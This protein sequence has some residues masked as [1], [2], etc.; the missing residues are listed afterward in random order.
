[1]LSAHNDGNK[2]KTAR[3]IVEVLEYFDEQHKAA[4]VMD[5]V[6]RY[7]RP[8]SSTSEL[9][10]TLVELG[11]LYKDNWSR[12]YTLTP[13]AAILG[14]VAQPEF[15]RHGVL[16]KMIDALSSEYG[17]SMGLF[18]MVGLNAQVFR[19]TLGT[20]HL[21]LRSGELCNGAQHQLCD[22][23]VGLLLLSTIQENR[24]AGLLRRLNAEAPE[25]KKFVP[26]QINAQVLEV[27]QRGW[28]TGPVG[29]DSDAHIAAILLPTDDGSRPV[30]LGFVYA[31]R[32]D[33]DSLGLIAALR[34]AVSQNGEPML[35]DANDLHG[36][37][38][39]AA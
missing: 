21:P 30:A 28:V 31:P 9:L 19:W 4:T 22:S 20:K 2:A 11:L 33:V 5:I 32:D 13:R 18:G 7:N 39:H 16:T 25:D 6:R 15:V 36:E 1:M 12:L 35:H 14:S 24:R 27:A 23:A 3:R 29:F 8:Q 34:A 26:S 10:A 17:F 37:L 38:L